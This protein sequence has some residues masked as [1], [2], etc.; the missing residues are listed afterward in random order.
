MT[1][2]TAQY[3]DFSRDILGRYVCNGF[4][5]A[6]Q[7]TQGA[8]ARPFDII[9]VG[10]GSFAA[11]LAQHI[12][13]RDAFRN[14]R[15]LMLEAGPVSLPG[16]LQKLP[17]LRPLAPRPATTDPGGPRHE[18]WGLPRRSSVARGVPPLAE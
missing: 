16:H 6:M 14:H 3:T 10:G 4:D 15:V 8:G 9:I 11:A 2:P 1:S 12:L 18:G 17:P 5:E 13:Y 7:S